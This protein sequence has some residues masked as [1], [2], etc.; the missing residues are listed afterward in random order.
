MGP[1][2][3][4]SSHVANFGQQSCLVCFANNSGIFKTF[5]HRPSARPDCATNA[6]VRSSTLRTLLS[7]FPISLVDLSVTCLDSNRSL[8]AG[9]NF[10]DLICVNCFRTFVRL[11]QSLQTLHRILRNIEYSSKQLQIQSEKKTD[12]ALRSRDDVAAATCSP[13]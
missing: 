5:L 9:L 1:S 4:A 8:L 10:R 11:L 7:A 2:N 12:S 3:Q 6:E 13:H